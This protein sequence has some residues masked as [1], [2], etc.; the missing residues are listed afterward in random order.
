MTS[1]LQRV[2]TDYS[3]SLVQV[4]ELS[5]T[6]RG[7]GGFGSTGVEQSTLQPSAVENGAKKFKA[8]VSEP[9][10]VGWNCP[11]FDRYLGTYRRWDISY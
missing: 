4:T 10:R 9:V 11:R 5:E 6:T 8:D 2:D 7:S 1:R 3:S